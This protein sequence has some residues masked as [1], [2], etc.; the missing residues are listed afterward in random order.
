[1]KLSQPSRR[2]AIF[3]VAAA[4]LP[5]AVVGTRVVAAQKP[6]TVAMQTVTEA[7]L[8]MHGVTLGMPATTAQPAISQ[9]VAEQ[10]AMA[11]F[12]GAKVRETVLTQVT[13][14]AH[15]PPIQCL[16]YAVSLT[17]GNLV[18]SE[19]PPGS[20]HMPATY[21]VAFMDASTGAFTFGI[22]N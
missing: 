12:P 19:G 10:A 21:L 11:H 7:Q 6:S 16:C 4:A 18:G 20:P 17:P 5:L 8:A 3:A 14:T 2:F 9:A 1:M 22:N 13:M 15:V